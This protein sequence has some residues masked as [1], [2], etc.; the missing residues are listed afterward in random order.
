MLA[1][2]GIWGFNLLSENPDW[3]PWLRWS[4]LVLS[5]GGS[6]AFIAAAAL[7]LKK[8][9]SVALVVGMLGG[10]GGT[11]AYSVATASVAH[12]GSIPSVGPSS[13]NTG[14]GGGFGAGPRG[15]SSGSTS[16]STSSLDSLLEKSMARWAAAVDGSQSAASLELSTGLAVMAIGGW[17]SDPAPTLAQ[18]EA[19]VKAGDIGYYIAGGQGGGGGFGGAIGGGSSTA[20]EIATWVAAHYTAQTIDG[21]TVYVLT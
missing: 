20:S 11:A 16:T 19:W 12:A 2:S 4:V 18:F 7:D 13:T 8:V 5:L 1:V 15:S 3:M 21:E 6:I 10:L 17:S 9:A 14:A